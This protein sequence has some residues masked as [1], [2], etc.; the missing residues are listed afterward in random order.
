MKPKH[1][2]LKLKPLLKVYSFTSQDAKRLGVSAA[3]L[4][5]YVKQ[6]HL[7]RIDRG[8]YRYISA[9]EFEDFQWEDL[10]VA[11]RRI[12][13]GVICLTTA[14]ILYDLTEEMPSQ[15]WIAIKHGTHHKAGPYVKV[16]RMR[17][18]E[19]GKTKI[20]IGKN[21]FSIFDQERTIVDAFRYLGSETALKALKEALKRKGKE[22]IN[23]EKL[24]K[25]AKQLRVKIKPFLI[26]MTI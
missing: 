22:K 19:L 11:M 10:A 5:Y 2:L 13:N 14:L 25:Y 7:Q 3:T 17:N 21:N 12:K 18:L 9:P 20:S 23:V 24:L 1:A 6:K 8:V 26:A 16:V 15:Y 4:A